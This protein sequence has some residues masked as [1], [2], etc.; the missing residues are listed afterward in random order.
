MVLLS[1]KTSNDQNNEDLKAYLKK[2]KVPLSDSCIYFFFPG[3]QCKNCFF[4]DGQKIHQGINEKLMVFSGF[5]DKRIKNFK[6]FYYDE[7]NEM[8]NLQFIDFGSR[9]ITC[10]NGKIKNIVPLHNFYH[11][12]DS[13]GVRK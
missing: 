1:C 2:F 3:N 12:M 5:P 7:K 4:F 6:H 10:E 13:M 11:Q 9:I 8:L